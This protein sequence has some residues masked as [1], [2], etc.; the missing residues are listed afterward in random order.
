[1]ESP[2]EVSCICHWYKSGLLHLIRQT[3]GSSILS[4]FSPLNKAARYYFLK[5]HVVLSPGCGKLLFEVCFGSHIAFFCNILL[6]SSSFTISVATIYISFFCESASLSCSN[7]QFT[8][9]LASLV[10]ASPT[11]IVSL[12]KVKC[13]AKLH[14]TSDVLHGAV[15]PISCVPMPWM[16]HMSDWT[17]CA[18]IK[19]F[20][21]FNESKIWT[22]QLLQKRID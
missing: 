6:Y 20:A 15:N 19:I 4:T 17:Y 14:V 2:F 9:F 7:T 12:L 22:S 5:E 21:Y 18:L 13:G 11:C 10:S 16:T 1:M 8:C 3:Q